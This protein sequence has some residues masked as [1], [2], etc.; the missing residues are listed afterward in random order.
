MLKPI[1]RIV[2]SFLIVLALLAG[3]S[4][5]YRLIFGFDL[6]R[7]AILA[8]QAVVYV[9]VGLRVRE[10][11]GKLNL[12]SVRPEEIAHHF[13]VSKAFALGRRASPLL[14]ALTGAGASAVIVLSVGML[15][16]VSLPAVAS[17]TGLFALYGALLALIKRRSL[18]RGV[19]RRHAD[20]YVGAH[21]RISVVAVPA[22]VV[23]WIALTGPESNPMLM[24]IIALGLFFWIG[25]LYHHLWEVLHTAL[26][27]LVYGEH[28]PQTVEWALVEWLRYTRKDA[29]VE[30]VEYEASSNRVTV[31]GR[32]ERPEELRS[33]LLKLDF[34]ERVHLV[35]QPTAS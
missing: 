25:Q 23:T 8:V 28:R 30:A 34:V 29:T 15:G 35:E 17:A 32:F 27:V 26:L 11:A 22:I 4:G 14:A 2:G 7:F 18:A 5:F 1:F 9:Y 21:R 24:A 20:G 31:H 12:V 13:E 10:W 3:V 16:F 6:I 19:L 33:D